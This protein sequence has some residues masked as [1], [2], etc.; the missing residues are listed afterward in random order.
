M[1]SHTASQR[2]LSTRGGSYDACPPSQSTPNANSGQLSFEE[3]VLKGLAPDGGLFIPEVI[4]SLPLNWQNDWLN[5]SFE[6]LAFQIFSLY[7]SAAEIP[8]S[9]LK[10]II[11]KSYSSFRVPNVTSTVTLDSDRRIHLLELFHWAD[12]CLQGCGV[13]VLGESV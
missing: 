3:V 6:E 12:F 11:H 13:A 1:A 7:I 4:P 8:P 10:D 9:A 2:Y 5:L